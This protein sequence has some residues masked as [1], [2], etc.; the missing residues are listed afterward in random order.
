MAVCWLALP[1]VSA[2]SALHAP[3]VTLGRPRALHARRGPA[4]VAMRA[5]YDG[6]DW[7]AQWYPIAWAEDC[8]VD[9]PFKATLFDEDYAVVV[10]SGDRPPIAMRDRCPHRLAALSEGRLTAQGWLQCSYHGF[11]FEG[12]TG[13]CASIPQLQ[14]PAQKAGQSLCAD[15]VAV[16]IVDGMVWLHPTAAPADAPPVPRDIPELAD[17][18]FKAV[19]AVRDFPVDYSLLIENIQDPSHFYFAHQRPTYDVYDASADAPQTVSVHDDPGERLELASSVLGVPKLTPPSPPKGKAKPQPPPPTATTRFIPPCTIVSC[20]RDAEG[21]TKFLTVFYVL[22][23]GVGRS[24]FLT[25]GVG[26]LPVMPP[27][28][29]QH[30]QLNNFL[31]QDTFLLATQQPHALGAELDA[32]EAG[33]PL[34]RRSLFSYRTPSEPMLVEV[35]KFLDSALPRMPRRYAAPERMRAPVGPREEVLDRWTQHTAICPDSQALVRTCRALSL[36]C[37]AALGALAFAQAYT[38]A[39][40]RPGVAVAA[41]LLMATWRAAARLGAEFRF[42]QTSERHQADMAAIPAVFDDSRLEGAAAS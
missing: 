37:R 4:T 5:A 1:L 15:A 34:R 8:R 35:G 20:R 13:R 38:R 23:V 7:E 24:R 25:A 9:Q 22:P 6:F 39:R 29:V 3:T 41:A 18:R 30:V 2:A 19:T 27:R 26:R 16:A 11:A 10:R 32:H 40:L 31:D 36:A 14:P 17:P 42:K 28:W 12:E 33:Q 21:E